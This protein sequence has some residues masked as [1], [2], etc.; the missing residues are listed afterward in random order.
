MCRLPKV[1]DKVTVRGRGVFVADLKGLVGRVVDILDGACGL[2]VAVRFPE[3]PGATCD[4]FWKKL[5][6]A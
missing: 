1:G 6:R 2:I 5:R 4:I 3:R